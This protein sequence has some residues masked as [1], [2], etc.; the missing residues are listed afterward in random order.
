MW[1][2]L[3]LLVVSVIVT[4]IPDNPIPANADLGNQGTSAADPSGGTGGAGGGGGSTGGGTGGGSAELSPVFFAPFSTEHDKE[5][6]V[7]VNF[8]VGA[9][10]WEVAK[11]GGITAGNKIGR[12][13][14]CNKWSKGIAFVYFGQEFPETVQI[15]VNMR[16][17]RERDSIG[18]IWG[19]QDK[20]NYWYYEQSGDPDL[21]C[22]QVVKVMKGKKTIE[23]TTRKPMGCFDEDCL[24]DIRQVGH[25][26]EVYM[27]DE[28]IITM[29]NHQTTGGKVGLYTMKSL[30][31]WWADMM[32]IRD[33]ASMDKPEGLEDAC[34]KNLKKSTC[35]KE[36]CVW[37]PHPEK[38]CR[39]PT[40]TL[41]CR[42]YKGPLTCANSGRCTWD[43]SGSWGANQEIC[44]PTMGQCGAHTRP[45][46]CRKGGCQWFDRKCRDDDFDLTYSDCDDIHTKVRCEDDERCYWAGDCHNTE[47]KTIR[48]PHYCKARDCIWLNFNVCVK[49]YTELE[50]RDYPNQGYCNK[51][52]E[53]GLQCVWDGG[54]NEIGQVLQCKDRK[55]NYKCREADG[56]TCFWSPTIKRCVDNISKDWWTF[57]TVT[58]IE[59]WA[60]LPQDISELDLFL[61]GHS[62]YIDASNFSKN[63]VSI[64]RHND[65]LGKTRNMMQVSVHDHTN[66]MAFDYMFTIDPKL[67]GDINYVKVGREYTDLSPGMW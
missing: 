8:G 26:I 43:R 19:F 27:N 6:W 4:A 51:A 37:H 17:T 60:A 11:D 3:K 52:I 49:D 21:G 67:F 48:R 12:G 58:N 36:D 42:D 1:V 33:E 25:H 23:A 38:T 32:V 30:L 7:R 15:S 2:T 20:E 22:Q 31:S 46:L 57:G 16:T 53:N 5:G 64:L 24:L 18:V 65:W 56:D 14:I 28:R 35:I 44:H 47:C 29:N 59:K 66:T 13:E 45:P 50:C 55:T 61:G 41:S 62:V 34:L 9:D 39:H 63:M 40:V 54:C 10:M